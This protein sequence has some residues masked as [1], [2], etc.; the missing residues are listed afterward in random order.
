MRLKKAQEV[1]RLF[2]SR[3]LLFGVETTDYGRLKKVVEQFAPFFYLWDTA[4]SWKSSYQNWM[5]DPFDTLDA[6]KIDE[7]VNGW[8]KGLFKTLRDFQKREIVSQATSCEHIRQ[9]VH[10]MLPFNDS[11]LTFGRFLM[12]TK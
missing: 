8:Y 6:E 7:N 12:Y 5:N 11:L 4:E 3:E 2:N 9:Q 1:T 10:I